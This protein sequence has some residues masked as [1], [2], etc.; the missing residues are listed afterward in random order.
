MPQLAAVE[1]DAARRQINRN[2]IIHEDRRVR[3]VAQHGANRL[4]DGDEAGYAG[5]KGAAKPAAAGADKAA[6]GGDKKDKK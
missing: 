6:A 1:Y 4:H 2:D 5:D 3:P